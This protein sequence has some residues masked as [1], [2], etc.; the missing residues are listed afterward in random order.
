MVPSTVFRYGCNSH[1]ALLTTPEMVSSA[2]AVLCASGRLQH[3]VEGPDQ[4]LALDIS[5]AARAT[6]LSRC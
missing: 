3:E 2:L 4:I 5:N 6:W 1:E